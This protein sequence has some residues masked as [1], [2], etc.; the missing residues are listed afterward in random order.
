MNS[1]LWILIKLRR[2]TNKRLSQGEK[3]NLRDIK[4]DVTG[5]VVNKLRFCQQKY[6]KANEFCLLAKFGG[7]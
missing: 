5:H 2:N 7:N 1:M 6:V 4:P 3:E